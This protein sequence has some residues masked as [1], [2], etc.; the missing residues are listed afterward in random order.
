MKEK[1]KMLLKQG[2]TKKFQRCS[3]LNMTSVAGL[4]AKREKI[5]FKYFE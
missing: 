1:A 3:S 2:F 4:F 5:F